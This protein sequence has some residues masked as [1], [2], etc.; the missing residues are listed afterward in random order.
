MQ[1]IRFTRQGDSRRRSRQVQ[2]RFARSKFFLH[3]VTKAA[4]PSANVAARRSNGSMRQRRGSKVQKKE[5]L[6]QKR[7]DFLYDAKKT[8]ELRRSR[9]EPAE[10]HCPAPQA[11]MP[12]PRVLREPRQRLRSFSSSWSCGWRACA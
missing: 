6:T 5:V 11:L 12:Q 7:G 9:L 3:F 8:L 2:K 10:G 1:R 4:E